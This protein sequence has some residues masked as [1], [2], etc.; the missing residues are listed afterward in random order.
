[1][2]VIFN[3]GY[4]IPRSIRKV[5]RKLDVPAEISADAGSLFVVCGAR[6]ADLGNVL[7]NGF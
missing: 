5:F 7:P 4:G 2:I 1:M 6:R 3:Y